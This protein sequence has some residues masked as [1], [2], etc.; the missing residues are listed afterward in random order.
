MA[1]NPSKAEICYRLLKTRITEGE[2]GNGYRLVIDQ[3]ARD[4]GISAIPWREAIR[5]LEAEGWLEVVP[6]VG[7]RVATF[8]TDAYA[9][10]I[11]VLA[12]LEGYATA[13]AMPNLTKVELDSAR[14]L[15]RHLAQ[16]LEDFDPIRFTALN[17]EF[18]LHLYNHCGDAH[19]YSLIESEWSRLDLIRR[20]PF[21]SVPGRARASVVEHDGLLTLL[22]Q[23]GS[24]DA[25]EAAAR[26]HKLNTLQAIY[27]HDAVARTAALDASHDA[28][29]RTA[30]A[31]APLYAGGEK[32]TA[33]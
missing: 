20:S 8:N 7:A 18:H 29:T 15:N 19:L 31:T 30:G 32:I 24:A 3:L 25:V 28:A 33:S 21:T 22:E 16:A 1:S 12:R 17:K 10:A 6:N 9:Q 4:T 11:Q 5:R 14:R 26:Q 13:L 2:Y 27:N 23:K